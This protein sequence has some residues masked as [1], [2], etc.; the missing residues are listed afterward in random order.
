VNQIG[1]NTMRNWIIWPPEKL[2]EILPPGYF[3][4]GAK[5]TYHE[6]QHTRC[7]YCQFTIAWVSTIDATEEEQNQMHTKLLGL[8]ETQY[9]LGLCPGHPKPPFDV[10]MSL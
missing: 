2:S 7:P 8:F 5:K 1:Q 10:F 4:Q 9:I 3:L 6:P